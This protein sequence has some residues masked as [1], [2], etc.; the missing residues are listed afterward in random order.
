MTI[1]DRLRALRLPAIAAP[2]FLVS[3]PDL[4]VAC[5]KAGIVGSFPAPN[6]RTSEELGDWMAEITNRLT[7]QDA[8]WALNL[9]THST[10]PRLEGDLQQVAKYHPPVVI[11]ALGSPKPVLPTVHDYGG[12]VFADVISVDLAKKAAAAGVDGLVLVCS[13]AGGHTGDLSPLVFVE[14]VRQF[15]DGYIALAGAINTGE[16]ILAAQVLGADFGYLGTSFLAAEENMASEEYRQ[17]CVDCGATDL[18]VTRAF[19]GARASMLKPSM[20]ARGLDPAELE[21]KVAKMNFTGRKDET[22]KPWSGIWGAGQGVGKVERVEPA[23]LIVDRLGR[24][25]EAA[26]ARGRE[27]CA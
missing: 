16:A 17:M 10:S 18:L 5:C 8:P 9:V 1:K 15:F 25:Y 14:R 6:L 7:P 22:V 20:I 19:T 27:L 21:F 2:M 11:T 4:V 3:T 23:A 13:G 26:R 24:E 12:L